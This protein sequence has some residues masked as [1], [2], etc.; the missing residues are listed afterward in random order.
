MWT[1]TSDFQI[2]PSALNCS[3]SEKPQPAKRAA[4]NSFRLYGLRSE[5]RPYT[6][7]PTLISEK[8]ATC[9]YPQ[10]PATTRNF[11]Q[12]QYAETNH[13]QRY[14]RRLPDR[15]GNCAQCF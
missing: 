6:A 15:N 4:Y 12:P 1:L 14:W 2:S 5:L 8:N 7:Q 11:V 3:L 13:F 9:N 10:L